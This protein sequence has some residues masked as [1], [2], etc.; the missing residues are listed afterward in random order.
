MRDDWILVEIV[1]VLGSAPRAEGTKM[2]VSSDSQVGSIG[3]GQ[4]ELAATD[5]ARNMIAEGL[6]D[7]QVSLPLGPILAQ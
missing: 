1:R 4:L 6:R 2:W 7:S 5:R 3:G